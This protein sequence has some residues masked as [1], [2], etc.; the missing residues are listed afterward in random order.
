MNRKG[1]VRNLDSYIDE[2]VTFDGALIWRVPSS[3]TK[4]PH[5]ILYRSSNL[6]LA[7]IVGLHN[8]IDKRSAESEGKLQSAL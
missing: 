6:N 8:C 7:A 1:T 4:D 5:I 2:I 3:R